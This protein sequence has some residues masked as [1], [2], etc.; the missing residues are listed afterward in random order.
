[1]QCRLSCLPETGDAERIATV[2]VGED[3]RVSLP[4]EHCSLYFLVAEEPAEP[5][6]SPTPAPDTSTPAPEEAADEPAS[7]FPVI[8]VAGGIVLLA[9][10]LAAI[11]WFRRR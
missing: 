8:P 2:T 10:V 1:M 7:G 3:G 6:A 9:A 11:L 5:S 4:L